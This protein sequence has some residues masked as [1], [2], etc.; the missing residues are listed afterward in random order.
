MLMLVVLVVDVAV[1]MLQYGM[2]MLML[3]ALRKMQ[4][5]SKPHESPRDNQFRRQGF[6]QDRNGDDC[7]DE[8]P[9]KKNRRLSWPL[10]G[11]AGRG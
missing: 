1:F 5:E 9:P 3:V 7:A 6:V 8:R 2:V 10:Q 11:G 4:P